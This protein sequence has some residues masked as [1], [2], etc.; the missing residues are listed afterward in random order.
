MR[1][2]VVKSKLVAYDNLF[3][4]CL[5][6]S[7]RAKTFCPI[8]I[9]FKP[10]FNFVYLRLYFFPWRLYRFFPIFY[11]FIHG[12]YHFVHPIYYRSTKVSIY[13]SYNMNTTPGPL[14][15]TFVFMLNL[16]AK[17]FLA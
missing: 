15:F 13:S 1:L 16:I 9:I 2:F 5:F 3:A 7:L 17:Y 14:Y 10:G 8:F 6:L 4:L 11:V 12:I